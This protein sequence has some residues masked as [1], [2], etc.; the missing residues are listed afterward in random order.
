MISKGLTPQMELLLHCART[1]VDP[2]R[3]QRIRTLSEG[4]LDWKSLNELAIQ[5]VM[6]PL[7]FW[8]LNQHIEK[9]I[10]K[11]NLPELETDFYNNVSRNLFMTDKLLGILDLF[12]GNG[13]QAIPYKGPVLTSTLYGNLSLR[14]FCDL[15]IVIREKDVETAERLLKSTGYIPLQEGQRKH[16]YHSQFLD[17][18]SQALVEIHWSFVHKHLGFAV[19]YDALWQRISFTN[20]QGTQVRTF[21]PEDLFLLLCVHGNKHRW[22]RLSWICDVA[23]M[24]L[25]QRNGWERIISSARKMRILRILWIA[26]FLTQD[27]IG[28]RHSET[29][30]KAMARDRTAKSL[31]LAAHRWIICQ[32]EP[33]WSEGAIFSSRSREHYRDQARCFHQYI[34]WTLRPRQE[35]NGSYSRRLA[36]LARQ[37]LGKFQSKAKANGR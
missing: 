24:I 16:H 3:L 6:R 26:L 4:P 37:A 8:N 31:A 11:R 19:D 20:L 12:E 18:K 30:R 25:Q 5:H 2:E 7:L 29:A 22:M 32:N 36:N 13:I 33:S 14:E 10:L 9:G 15:D 21:H 34:Q 23:Q 1:D 17:S 35:D 28:S 27:L